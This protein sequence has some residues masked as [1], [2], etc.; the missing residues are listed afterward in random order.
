MKYNKR[1]LDYRL[2]APV[3]LVKRKENQS[4]ILRSQQIVMQTGMGV[5]ATANRRFNISY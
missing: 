1:G 2:T 3:N 5:V 4:H